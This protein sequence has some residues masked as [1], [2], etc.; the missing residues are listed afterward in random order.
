MTNLDIKNAYVGSTSVT[1][2]Y[3]G[4][5]KIY[6]HKVLYR[7]K[8]YDFVYSDGTWSTLYDTSKTC[9]GV[10]TDV[11][12]MDFDFM[13]LHNA[14]TNKT[15]FGGT[16]TLIT[17][18]VTT[19]D[20]AVA[21]LDFNGKSNTE[22]I[23]T[24]LGDSALA[25]K[26]CAKYSTEG[27]PAGSWYLPAL[28]QLMASCV[29]FT[30]LTDALQTAGGTTLEDTGEDPII[31]STQRD[32]NSAYQMGASTNVYISSP[33]KSS[34]GWVRPFCTV[35]YNH[36][37][38]GIYICDKDNNYYTDTQWTA[39]GKASSDAIGIALVTDETQFLISKVR[40]RR[41]IFSPTS[42][43]N[44]LYAVGNSD[45]AL[46]DYAGRINTKLLLKQSTEH[47]AADATNF[48]IGNGSTGF[49]G[50]L[51]EWSKIVENVDTINSYS[52]L[53]GL[54]NFNTTGVTYYWTSTSSTPTT[55]YAYDMSTK[56]VASASKTNFYNNVP[57]ALLPYKGNKEVET[58]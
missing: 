58:T 1:A 35:E 27:F 57:L 5:T 8:V 18:I 56:V 20:K 48:S 52:A 33:Y 3:L 39:S 13:A 24:Q 50:S 36:I 28:G 16:G 17:D 25:A 44:M 38:N 6:P 32:L 11:R 21:R 29:S 7:P 47:A 53:I 42:N 26:A 15:I 37:D 41:K 23:I 10:I 46:K 45:Y 49:I 30:D 4:S 12:S 22:K 31:C 40:A 14:T 19:K 43:A 34:V 9:V 2:M 55:E 54:N 51:G